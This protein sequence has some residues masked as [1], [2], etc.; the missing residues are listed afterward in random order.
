[1][2]LA[3]HR[4]IVGTP[5]GPWA[6]ASDGRAVVYCLPVGSEADSCCGRPDDLCREAASQLS[7]YF[8]GRRTTFD[9]PYHIEGTDFQKRVW[10]CAGL[11][12]YGRMVSYSRLAGM[13]GCPQAARAVGGALHRN[14][15]MLVVP[16]HRI[17]RNDGAAGGFAAGSAV[18]QYLLDLE[19]ENEGLL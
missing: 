8:L 9:F 17:V 6:V 10:R 19:R 11:V 18:K 1:M 13:M 5:V 12:P 3:R 4:I 15:L 14:V 16:C 7:A 2:I